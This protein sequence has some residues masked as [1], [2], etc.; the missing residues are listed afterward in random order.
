MPHSTYFHRSRS[1]Y[2]G[3]GSTTQSAPD[4]NQ[5][6][7]R[8]MCHLFSAELPP[9]CLVKLKFWDRLCIDTRNV[10]RPIMPGFDYS[11]HLSQRRLHSNPHCEA[12]RL[13]FCSA[14]LHM[15]LH[16]LAGSPHRR[17]ILMIGD[18]MVQLPHKLGIV[19]AG[20]DTE[21]CRP[22]LRSRPHAAPPQG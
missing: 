4:P 10:Q 5:S 17:R 6:A 7:L 8:H 16:H 9:H 13:A 2:A 18:C 12:A 1:T 11:A 3:T 14:N 20:C 21:E 15:F 22:I 19:G